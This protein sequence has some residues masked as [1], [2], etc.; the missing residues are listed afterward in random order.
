MLFFQRIS[1]AKR[2]LL[3]HQG[4]E[5]A[6]SGKEQALVPVVPA[7]R[8]RR[9]GLGHAEVLQRRAENQNAPVVLSVRRAGEE[10]RRYEGGSHKNG[11]NGS[12]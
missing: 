1:S 10:L 11:E 5:K 6:R 12:F 8:P 7:S 3:F 2:V 9:Q 4:R